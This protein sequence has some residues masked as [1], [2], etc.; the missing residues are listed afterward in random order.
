MKVDDAPGSE[1]AV[2]ELLPNAVGNREGVLGFGF[3]AR[4]LKRSIC[5]ARFLSPE[6]QLPVMES[7]GVHPMKCAGDVLR[8]SYRSK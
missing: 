3:V 5:L 7:I 8:P 4:L 6:C 2:R 1:N